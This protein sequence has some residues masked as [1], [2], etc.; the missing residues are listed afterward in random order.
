[1][2]ATAKKIQD[3]RL[4]ALAVGMKLDNFSM[5]KEKVQKMVDDLTKEKVT[6]LKTRDECM[7]NLKD[8]AADTAARNDEKRSL[9]T[10][11][12]DLTMAISNL[13]DDIANANN[14]ISA[15][16]IGM[17]RA[18]EDREAANKEFQTTVGDQRATQM[19]L[20]KAMERLQ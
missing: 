20:Q 6:E 13:K 19:I 7:A 4:S 5:V 18:S 1:M 14:E 2:I 3:P 11:M 9:Q 17:K 15:T 10:N 16:M 12:D 8:N